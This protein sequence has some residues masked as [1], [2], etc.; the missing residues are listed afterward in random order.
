MELE[1]NEDEDTRSQILK[2]IKSTMTSLGELMVVLSQDVAIPFA[3]G[4]I[5]VVIEL[6]QYLALFFNEGIVI[7]WHEAEADALR[8]IFSFLDHVSQT[9]TGA[10]VAL[11]DTADIRNLA[12]ETLATIVRRLQRHLLCE[13]C[14][15]QYCAGNGPTRV[16]A[17]QVED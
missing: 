7:P 12:A 8:S 16:A 5:I 9:V 13:R 3:L 10:P 17:Q 4:V 2:F 11:T 1:V 15:R 14:H 6:I